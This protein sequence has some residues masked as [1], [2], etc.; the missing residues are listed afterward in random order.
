MAKRK[1]TKSESLVTIL[2]SIRDPRVDRTKRH[3]LCDILTIGLCAMLAGHSDFTV[4]HAFAVAKE[5]FLRQFLELPNGIPSHDTFGRVFAAIDPDEF[6]EAFMRWT[7]TV[8]RACHA[9]VV[10]ID[11]KALRRAKDAGEQAPVIVGAWGAQAG[12]SLGQIK[13]DEKSNEWERSGHRLP[14]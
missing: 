14:S 2:S 8:R 5:K 11:G 7:R 6:P 3:K 13:V 9:R 10:A 1:P 4:M 12:I